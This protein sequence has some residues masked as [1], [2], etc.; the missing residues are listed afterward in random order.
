MRAALSIR[1]MRPETS[2]VECRH[3]AVEDAK[4]ALGER[5]PVWWDNGA[6]DLKRK[7]ARNTL[8]DDWLTGDLRSQMQGP[9]SLDHGGHGLYRTSLSNGL[10]PQKPCQCDKDIR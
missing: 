6:P 8:C 7:M 9:V 10:R 4:V 5:G 2:Q 3:H 1:P